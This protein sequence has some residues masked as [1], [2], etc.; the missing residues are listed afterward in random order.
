[1][2]NGVRTFKGVPFAQPPVGP[3]RWAPP[4]AITWT[5]DRDATKFQLPCPQPI[6]A[7]GS[8]G[9][10]VSGDT[11]EDCLTLNVFAPE[12]VR[13]APV[14]LWLFGGAG[15]LGGA[16]LPTYGGSTFAKNGVMVV[17]IN[18]RLGALGGFA[19][20]A[21][22]KAAKPGE[23]LSNYALMDAIAG[24]EWVKRN[25]AAF[26][27]DPGNVTLF[28]QSAGGAMV[29]QLLSSPPAKGLFH[30]AIIH[31]GT[32]LSAGIT[33]AEG[34]AQGAKM[35][36]ALGLKG[37]DATVAELRALPASAFVG[38]SA[39]REGIR[40]VLDGKIKTVSTR[41]GFANGATFDVPLIAG[42]NA[43]E[44]GAD[45]ANDIVNLASGGAASY[46]YYFTYVP[47][48][49]KAA[50]PNGPPHSAEL[51]YAFAS[52]GVSSPEKDRGVARRLNSCWVAFA[53]APATTRAL[54]CADG[55]VWQSRT[56]E[57]DALAVFGEMPR[58]EKATPIVAENAKRTAAPAR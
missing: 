24:L 29:S 52:L 43:G 46:Q 3:L 22:T 39:V 32:N 20:P 25:A 10:G 48:A 34:E 33:L 38:N 47:D 17:T 21:L 13:N 56:K 28:G 37:A 57:N 26:G 8:N 15:Y 14:M 42:S 40:G 5:G 51:R 2:E 4:Q 35:A 45:R 44:G 30:K 31:S 55:F 1:M 16:H 58:L 19:H 6:P 36:T 9:G 11:S 23:G 18:Y 49:R 12:G 54:S 27:G 41:A 50:Q 7:S 53:K